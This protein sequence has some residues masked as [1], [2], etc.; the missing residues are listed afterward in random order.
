MDYRRDDKNSLYKQ[1]AFHILDFTFN[2]P[3]QI[4]VDTQ[5]SCWTY[6]WNSRKKRL[7]LLVASSHYR[8][9]WWRLFDFQWSKV[10]PLPEPS[11]RQRNKVVQWHNRHGGHQYQ[12]KKPFLRAPWSVLFSTIFQMGWYHHLSKRRNGEGIL[13]L[14]ELGS[15]EFGSFPLPK[16]NNRLDSHCV[17]HVFVRVDS[18]IVL[19]RKPWNLH[20][21]CN[22]CAQRFGFWD[23]FLGPSE[24]A[25]KTTVLEF[26]NLSNK[27]C[28]LHNKMVFFMKQRFINGLA[29]WQQW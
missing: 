20:W 19:G 12:R 4:F 23:V 11:H 6:R 17:C 13:E 14:C 29:H 7:C 25:E 18:K 26:E 5:V 24:R 1:Q 22:R 3:L 8:R 15:L 16:I 28:N 9:R 10:G 27:F 21:V 2:V